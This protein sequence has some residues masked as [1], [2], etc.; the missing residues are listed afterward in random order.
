M[1]LLIRANPKIPIPIQLS[2]ILPNSAQFSLSIFKAFLPLKMH[3]EAQF[4]IDQK[5]RNS[6]QVDQEEN[7]FLTSMVFLFNLLYILLHH[8]VSNGRKLTFNIQF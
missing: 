1:V 7:S 8:H 2:T 6:Q 5:I 4:Q 3:F